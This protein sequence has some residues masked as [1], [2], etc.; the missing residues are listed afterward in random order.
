M[1]EFTTGSI[2]PVLTWDEQ[3]TFEDVVENIKT[4]VSKYTGWLYIS[5]ELENGILRIYAKNQPDSQARFLLSYDVK[6]EREIYGNLW[7]VGFYQS[8]ITE[9]KKLL[10]L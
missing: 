1:R 3:N 2:D 8:R 10:T 7:H 5:V 9:L 6:N 4:H